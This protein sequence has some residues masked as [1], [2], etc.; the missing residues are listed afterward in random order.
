M[1]SRHYLGSINHT[2]LT[3]KVLTDKGFKPYI[4]F[5]GNRH[6][7]TEAIIRSKTGCRVLG[8]IGEQAVF[9]KTVV[10]SLAE[11]IQPSLKQYQLM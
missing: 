8:R 5:S 4:L 10:R 7:S 2:L 6:P 11:N 3:L 9:D 1:V